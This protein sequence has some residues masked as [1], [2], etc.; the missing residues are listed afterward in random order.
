MTEIDRRQPAHHDGIN[1]EIGVIAEFAE[2]H[3]CP[4]LFME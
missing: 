3:R 4:S 1:H 2:L